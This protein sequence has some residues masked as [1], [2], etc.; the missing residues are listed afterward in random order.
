MDPPPPPMA[1]DP[2]AERGPD[3]SLVLLHRSQRV[4]SFGRRLIVADVARE[5]SPGVWTGPPAAAANEGHRRAAEMCVCGGGLWLK[6]V[7]GVSKR[8]NA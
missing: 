4:A 3:R 5:R 7:D 2:A 1:V 6:M 8:R